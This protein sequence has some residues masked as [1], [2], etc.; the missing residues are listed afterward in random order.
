MAILIFAVLLLAGWL[1]VRGSRRATV[2]VVWTVALCAV[3]AVF[4]HHM[5]AKLSL[6]F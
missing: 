3:L 4:N 5:A 1:T 2:L 6:N